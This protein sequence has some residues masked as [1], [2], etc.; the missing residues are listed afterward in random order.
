MSEISKE[1][2]KEV[3]D[4]SLN[5]L[6]WVDQA[7]HKEHHS[8]VESLIEKEHRKQERWEKIKTQVLGWGIMV[9][10]GSIGAWVLNH[11]KFE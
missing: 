10:V 11:I 4:A 1:D 2:L 6:K 7:T 5:E 3:L 9:V 8:F